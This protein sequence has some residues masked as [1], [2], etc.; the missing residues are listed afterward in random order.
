MNIL[1]LNWRDPSHPKA[2]GAE[3]V[4][5]EHAKGW[6]KHGHSVQWLTSRHTT[7][8]SD[9]TIAGVRI[10]RRGGSL[11]VY[12][13]GFFFVLFFGHRYDVIVDEIH[14][15]PFLTP[16]ITRTPIVAFIHEVAGEIWN[17]M[18]PFPLSA[19][20][21][22]IEK[23]YFPLYRNVLFWTDAESTIDELS[24]FGI[25]RKHCKAIPC[26]II[27]PLAK[28][29][30]KKEKDPTY[31]FVSRL[32]PMKGVEVVLHAF[33]SIRKK[34]SGARLWLLGGGDS[35]YV[36]SLKRMVQ[37]LEIE[38]AVTF[39]GR[40]S[41]T[42]KIER[43][44]RAHILL[45]ASVKEGWGLVVLEAA[46]QGTPSV[47]YNVS[48][49]RDVVHNHKT[50]IVLQKNSSEFLAREAIALSENSVQYKAFQKAGQAWVSSLTWDNVVMESLELLKQAILRKK[51]L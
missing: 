35:T 44:G 38:S 23:L 5:L 18:V 6:V 20:G 14:A 36:Q 19:I 11:T 26:P 40:V 7:V 34:Q 50:G 15:L 25:P 12:I 32:V 41:D 28:K 22:L 9:E 24:L 29:P 39:Y 21:R 17:Y 42:E 46:S 4:T 10:L 1:L 30:W 27:H 8:P 37:E 48:G 2:G 33:A 3:I 16:L 51:T 47:V 43:L 31:I 49:L 13:Y 45:H